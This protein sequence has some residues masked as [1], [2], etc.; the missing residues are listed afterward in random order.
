M[1]YLYKFY[2]ILSQKYFRYKFSKLSKLG[3]N[4][5]FSRKT[6]LVLKNGAKRENLYLGDNSK[7]HGRIILSNEGQVYMGK[8]TQ[9]GPNSIIGALRRIVI[10][11]YTAIAANVRIMDNNNHPVNPIDRY[12]LQLTPHNSPYRQWYYS[13]SSSIYIGKNV[14]IGEFVRIC[15]GVTI[16]DNSIVAAN[17]VVTKNVPANCIVAGNPARIVKRDIENVG[18][19]I[20]CDIPIKCLRE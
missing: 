20:K 12:L 14:W 8:F 6:S 19:R 10:G 7:V 9:L 18:R 11:D 5:V 15:K 1:K 17:S 3:K 4:V 16:G 13:L 2:C